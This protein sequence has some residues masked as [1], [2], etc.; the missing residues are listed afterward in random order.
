[1]VAASPS[2]VQGE[3]PEVQDVLR[4]YTRVETSWHKMD[5]GI[6]ELFKRSKPWVDFTDRFDEFCVWISRLEKK[7]QNGEREVDEMAEV[8]GG[9]LSDK[10]VLFK[11]G[12][13][14]TR[15]RCKCIY[16]YECS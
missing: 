11:V 5:G 12:Y 6:T 9:D 8:D 13:G 16:L 14:Y 7:V 10:I 4:R 15:D 3:E 1:M 2:H